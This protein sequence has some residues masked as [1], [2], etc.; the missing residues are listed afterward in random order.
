MESSN[1]VNF[2]PLWNNNHFQF[3]DCVCHVNAMFVIYFEIIVCSHH[4]NWKVLCLGTMQHSRSS[5][6]LSQVNSSA[7]E[8]SNW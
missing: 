3:S 1:N 5:G 2:C 4:R 7:C 8:A 6:D